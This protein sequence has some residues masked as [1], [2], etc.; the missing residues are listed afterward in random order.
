VRRGDLDVEV[1][2]PAPHAIHVEIRAVQ[3]ELWRAMISGVISTAVKSAATGSMP[4]LLLTTTG[5]KSGRARAAPRMIVSR[6]RPSFTSAAC[7]EAS[8][9]APAPSPARA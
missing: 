9:H 1:A 6:R 7:A 8:W 5:R 3:I 4:V 2:A